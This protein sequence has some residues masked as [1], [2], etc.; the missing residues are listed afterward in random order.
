MNR[1]SHS[2]HEAL[3][4]L[5][6]QLPLKLRSR[7]NADVLAAAVAEHVIDL[8]P[9]G[10]LVWRLGSKTLLAH[11]CGRMWCGDT[12]VYNPRRR[13]WRWQLGEGNFPEKD[14]CRLFGV[15]G[16]RNLRRQRD[17]CAPPCGFE[18]IDR[19]FSSHLA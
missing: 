16:L 3:A 7:A 18:L 10:Q 4:A 11:F 9:E 8:T 12:L 19:L 5:V 13:S 6:R 2:T 15:Q 17:L 14:L 1:I